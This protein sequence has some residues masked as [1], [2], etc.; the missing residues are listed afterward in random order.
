MALAQAGKRM[1]TFNGTVEGKIIADPRGNGGFGYDP[2]F[3]PDGYANTFAE[4]PPDVK[5]RI[6]HRAQALQLTHRFLL[7]IACESGTAG[8]NPHPE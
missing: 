2:L 8:A 4:L 7:E 3:V 1:A 6:S 5:N